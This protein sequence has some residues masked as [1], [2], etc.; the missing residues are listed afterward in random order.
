MLKTESRNPKTLH[1]DKMDTIEQ[2]RIM[3]EENYNAVKA[4]EAELKSIETAV[5]NITKALK[6]SG[7][8][9]YIGAGTSGRLGVLDAA[10]CPPTFGVDYD[11]VIGIIAGGDSALRKASEGAEDDP[12]AGIEEL[13]RYML[14]E[15][16]VVVGI[17]AAGGA[18][19]V[20]NAV[21][22][23]ASV[24]CCTIGITSN[25]ES[26]LDKISEISICTDTGAEVITGSTRLKAGTAQKLVL[27]MLTT[28]SMIRCGYVY[29]N[30]MI[31]L[32]PTNIKLKN[33]MIGIVSDILKCADK[34]AEKQLQLNDWNIR[35]T[36]SA[37]NTAKE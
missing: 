35:K 18:A 8:L 2:L 36:V 10:E 11:R 30:M 25:K 34:E 15:N 17:S 12:Q 5:I 22:Y 26:P 37:V 19:Y 28:V 4:V 14:N 27:N 31:N 33:R 32:K 24:G 13:K 29:E 7:R 16:D 20:V 23:A 6:H 9:F 21:K 3:N 1:I